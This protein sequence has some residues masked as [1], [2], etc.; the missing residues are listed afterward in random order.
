MYTP[1]S[2]AVDDLPTH[3]D[4]IDHHGFATLISQS[5]EPLASH[6]PFLLDRQAAPQGRLRSHMARANPQ[7][8]SADG[9]RVLVIFNGPHAYISPRWYAA[10]N[11]VPTWNY[12]AVHVYGTLR[13]VDDGATV[14]RIVDETVARYEADSPQPWRYAGDA[15]FLDRLLQMIVG[16]EIDIDRIEGKWKLSQNHPVERRE[17]VIRGLREIGD[18]AADDIARLMQETLDR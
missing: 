5:D 3:H 9:S 11:V 10:E 6:L 4:F 7:W 13:L 14:S 17:G 12:V 8:K 18:P 1:A 16:F 2:F 15:D